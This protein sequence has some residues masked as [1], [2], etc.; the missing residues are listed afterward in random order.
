MKAIEVDFNASTEDEHVRLTTRGAVQSLASSGNQPGDW[1]W[2]TDGELLVGA[3]LATDPYYGLVGIPAWDT[4]VHLDDE[5]ADDFNII[6]RELQPMLRRENDSIQDE[7]RIFQLCTQ[8]ERLAP[9]GLD[10]EP[11]YLSMRRALALRALGRTGL[12]LLEINDARR[13]RPHDPLVNFVYLDLLRRQDLPTAVIEAESLAQTPY[14]PAVVLTACI[15]ILATVAEEAPDDQFE[16]IARR[17][18]EWCDRLMRT[19]D[20]VSVVPPLIAMSFFNRGV[21][22]LRLGRIAEA[23]DA[24][25][26]AHKIYPLDTTFDEAT[27]LD[28]YDERARDLAHHVRERPTPI[29]A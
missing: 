16:P 10:L 17:V 4:L 1:V 5:G 14:V 26:H 9:P 28:A 11:G 2:L 15:T 23:Q 19:P 20:R 21:M 29:A 22:L 25:R 24:F 18:L 8:L 6:W 7:A 3:Q 12:A 27:R 13:A